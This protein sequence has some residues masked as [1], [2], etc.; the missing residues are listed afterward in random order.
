VPVPGGKTLQLAAEMVNKGTLIAMD[1]SEYKLK[2]LE[3]RTQR[4]GVD[5]V[6]T[7]LIKS[8]AS[9]K[10]F[11]GKADKLLLDVPCSGSGVIRR[12]VDTKWKL[13]PEHVERN[14]AI[15]R[16]ILHNYTQMLKPGGTLVYATCS[17]FKSENE[18]QV[19][20]FLEQHP[21][22]RLVEE[23]RLN[24]GKDNDGFYMAR[25]KKNG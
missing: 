4:N 25:M 15:Q 24:P 18:D 14:I 21:E 9:I 8:P 7:A 6:Q 1:I 10:A 16:D 22:F 11:A 5:I 12:D 2:E 23:K 17:I 3:K 13:Q 19:Q 20:W